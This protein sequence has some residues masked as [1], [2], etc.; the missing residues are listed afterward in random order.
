MASNADSP[1]LIVVTGFGPY[2]NYFVNSS[3]EAVK[4][5]AKLGLGDNFQLKILELPVK[6]S[7]V[8]KKIKW[9]WTEVQPQLSVHVGMMSSSKAIALEQCGRNKGYMEKDL[10]GAHPQGGCCLLEGPDRIESA[11][12][13]KSICKNLSWPGVHV[14]HSRDAGRY[15]CEYAYYISLHCGS[16]KA[17]FIH[18]PP[19]SRIITAEILGQALQI[20]IQEVLRQL[21]LLCD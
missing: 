20:I 19:L 6:Y 18:V 5:L 1:N 4:E 12:N 13:M 3:W 8:E 14:I 17:V 9:I 2:R 7:A 11:V 21:N 15:L 10:S 16:G